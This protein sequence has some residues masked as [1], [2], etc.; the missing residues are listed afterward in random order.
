MKVDNFCCEMST[1]NKK[2]DKQGLQFRVHKVM[3]TGNRYSDFFQS[4]SYIMSIIYKQLR[5]IGSQFTGECSN[6]EP[7]FAIMLKLNIEN[8]LNDV[9]CTAV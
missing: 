9:R 6:L 8:E 4:K 1:I 2:F 7:K 3:W 5:S